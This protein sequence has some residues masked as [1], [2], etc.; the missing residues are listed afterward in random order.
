MV[1]RM[2]ITTA[3]CR[4]EGA[5]AMVAAS[6]SAASAGRMTTPRIGLAVSGGGFRATCFGLGCLRALH[7]QDL[8]RHVSVI[9][10][11]SGGSLIAAL[12][13]YGPPNFEAF[14]T[15]VTELLRKGLQ[16]EVVRRV[17]SP[18]V[19]VLNAVQTL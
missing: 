16:G 10:G 1:R 8:L 7:D 18:G 17:L 9:S 5:Q 13:A 15:Q 12:Y 2:A 3:A 4:Q 19:L 6:I 11:I 14:D